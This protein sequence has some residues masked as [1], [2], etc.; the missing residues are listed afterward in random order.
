[1]G[2]LSLE[3]APFVWSVTLGTWIYMPEL[4]PDVD[5]AWGYLFK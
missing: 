5:G 4:A 1:M 3:F 2:R